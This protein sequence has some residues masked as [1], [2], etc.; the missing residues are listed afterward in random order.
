VIRANRR[1][2]FLLSSVLGRP[3]GALFFVGGLKPANVLAGASPMP[4]VNTG[5]CANCGLSRDADDA[6]EYKLL[7]S[8]TLSS[9][10]T[11]RTG[12]RHDLQLWDPDILLYRAAV[13]RAR[14]P[15]IWL[16][17]HSLYAFGLQP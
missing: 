1:R 7:H 3:A 9:G 12:G 14:P 17:P 15:Q 11:R 10:A 8:G 13:S 5:F 6:Y 16:A 4:A 2:E